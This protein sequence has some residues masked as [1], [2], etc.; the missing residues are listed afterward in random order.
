MLSTLVN[1]TWSLNNAL[2]SYAGGTYA[3]KSYAVSITTSQ[4][5]EGLDG[6]KEPA[7]TFDGISVGYSG[8]MEQNRVRFHADGYY[9]MAYGHD[10]KTLPDTW[11]SVVSVS[12]TITGGTDATN[13]DLI[14]WLEDNATNL[15]PVPV[16]TYVTTST[17]LTSIAN[18]IRTKG[19]TSAALVYPTGFVSAIND[20]TP[21]PNYVGP[22]VPRRSSSDLTASG[23][24]VNV[25]AGYY[26]SAAS[27]AVASGSARTPSTTIT[28]NPTI[29][30]SSAGLI[31]AS[32]S[33]SK[34]VTPSVTA[35]YVASGTA[36]TVTVTGSKT[37][38]LTVYNGAHHQPAP[39]PATVTISL[40]NPVNATS[41][42]GGYIDELYSDDLHDTGTTLATINS[43]TS[44]TTVTVS[45]GIYGIQLVLSGYYPAYL[46]SGYV[47]CSG[48][49]S[50][51]DSDNGAANFAVTGDGT[52]IVDGFDYNDD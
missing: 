25:P 35:G 3:E 43:P 6:T 48:G 50:L 11:T 21:D 49:V 34:S 42:T 31:T 28:A 36:G 2:T 8:G 26:A 41:F 44:T 16:V 29:S 51:G 30:V 39:P 52:I 38:Q 12:F 5:T 37:Q 47:T 17:E 32:V 46:G 10:T 23:A 20:I 19:G 9:L 14:A 24:T 7:N 40:T 18:A 1:T 15:A 22:G 45:G 27:K 33:G 13:S 4:P